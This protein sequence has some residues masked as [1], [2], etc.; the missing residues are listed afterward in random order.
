MHDDS[1]G[2]GIVIRQRTGD[3]TR[4][5]LP[6]T[7]TAT[8]PSPSRD[9]SLTGFYSGSATGGA[10]AQAT[11]PVVTPVHDVHRAWRFTRLWHHNP[12]VSAPVKTPV[13]AQVHDDSRGYCTVTHQRSGDRT[14]AQLSP[15]TPLN[16]HRRKTMAKQVT[17]TVM[18]PEQ[19]TLTRNR[20][21]DNTGENIAAR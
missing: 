5:R 4:S 13:K 7:T 21:G 3:R 9:D 6:P 20:T 14:S 19:R 11:A 16:R 8:A 2:H 15:T 18:F 1:R 12:S 10:H 17:T